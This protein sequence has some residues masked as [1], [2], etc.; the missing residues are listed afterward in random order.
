MEPEQGRLFR[1]RLLRC[2][3]RKMT[4]PETSLNRTRTICTEASALALTCLS[5]RRHVVVTLCLSMVAFGASADDTPAPSF[6]QI[7]LNAGVY[8]Y[9]FDESKNLRNN[10]IG[11]GAE[12]ALT[13]NHELLAGTYIN[14]NDERTR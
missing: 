10:N 7:W 14:S 8:S 9:H 3:D 5:I 2:S 1:D 11:F 12:L 4:L 6:P 13:R